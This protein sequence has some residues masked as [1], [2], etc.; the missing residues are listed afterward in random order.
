[1]K[2][3]RQKCLTSFKNNPD[4]AFRFTL[5]KDLGMTVSQ[6]MTTMSLKEYNQWATYYLWEQEERNKAI[7]IADAESKKRKR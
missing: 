4:L 2:T 7:A 5:A 6:L 1:M 3:N